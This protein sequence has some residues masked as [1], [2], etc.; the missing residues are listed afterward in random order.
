MSIFLYKKIYL[1]SG[2]LR[3]GC[4]PGASRRLATPRTQLTAIPR[5]RVFVHI[6]LD[7]FGRAQRRTINHN[8]T[9]KICY[10]STFRVSVTLQ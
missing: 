7:G 1:F 3:L 9:L 2:P 5:L 10:P 8:N 6:R 4:R